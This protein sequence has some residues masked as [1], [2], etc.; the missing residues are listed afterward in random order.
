MELVLD[1]LSP[2]EG[3]VDQYSVVDTSN[4]PRR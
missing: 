3:M 2:A 1:L 4:H